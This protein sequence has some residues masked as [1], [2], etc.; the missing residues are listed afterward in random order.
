MGSN[1]YILIILIPVVILFVWVSKRSK[2]GQQSD[3]GGN[4]RGSNKRDEVWR[5]IKEF[6]KNE[7]QKGLEVISTYSIRRPTAKELHARLKDA[8]I[9]NAKQLAKEQKQKYKKP[10]IPKKYELE[11]YFANLYEQTFEL[12]K[13]YYQA[14]THQNQTVDVQIFDKSHR[15]DLINKQ[16]ARQQWKK[17]IKTN[18]TFWKK[19]NTQND[20]TPTIPKKRDLYVLLFKTKNQK[21]NE[22][23]PTRA[24]EVEIV[25]TPLEKGNTQ[26]RILVNQEL[27]IDKEMAWIRPIKFA[28]DQ[29]QLQDLQKMQKLEQKQKLKLQKW[30]QNQLWYQKLTPKFALAWV[31]KITS[32]K[33]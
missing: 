16:K 2:K 3:L 21:T 25:K 6:L 10:I 7:N 31:N 23:L 12:S 4:E 5:T 18:L 9:F 29:K 26:R 17:Q 24:I 33:K 19:T 22:I 27:D 30:H 13:P 32:P 28:D 11:D 14:H 20:L 1:L 8:Q 15:S